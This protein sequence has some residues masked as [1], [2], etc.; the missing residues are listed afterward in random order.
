[1]STVLTKDFWKYFFN[2]FKESKWLLVKYIFVS[3]YYIVSSVIAN[4]MNLDNLTYYNAIISLIFFGDMIAFGMSEAFGV[5]INQNIHDKNKASSYVKIGLYF[6]II[7]S[8]VL[9]AF[10]IIFKDFVLYRLLGLSGPLSYTFYYI[11]LAYM[12]FV[13]I[14][15]YIVNIFKKLKSYLLQLISCAIQSVLIILG[16]VI[17]ML[18]NGL[19]LWLI[20]TVYLFSSIVC[21][22]CSAYWLAKNK[23]LPVNIAKLQRIFLTKSEF[24][25]LLAIS[26]SEIVWEIGYMMLSLFVLKNNVVIFNSY[27]Y[28]ENVLDI[29]Q[30]FLFA[31]VNVTSIKICIAI[32][33]GKKDE[34]Y[35]HGKYALWASVVIW[36]MYAMIIFALF[37][38]IRMGMNVELRSSALL[39]MTLYIVMSLFRFV[40]WTINSYTLQQS[41]RLS[42]YLLIQEI[43]S[44][45]YF[46]LLYIFA[47]KIPSNIFLIYFLLS[48]ESIIKIIICLVIFCKKKWLEGIKEQK[49][50]QVPDN[51]E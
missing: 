49:A 30:G 10:M 4:T 18:S 38:P 31:F 35:M 27:S 12:V 47:T 41:G 37:I 34:A 1:M 16:F 7:F 36:I 15:N 13:A 43:I 33:E 28:Y 51:I 6:T 48:I 11:M 24:G 40:S 20:G 21:V 26:A 3:L 23:T 14:F 46:V 17:L 39:S 25:K 42:T 8:V 29:S 19:M 2:T 50:V 22:V 45:L 9:V 5:Y 44:T 32:G